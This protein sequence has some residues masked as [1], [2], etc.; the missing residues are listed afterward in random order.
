MEYEAIKVVETEGGVWELIL[1]NPPANALSK[2]MAYELRHAAAQLSTDPSVRSVVLHGEGKVFFGGGDLV[3]F[4]DGGGQTPANLHEMT[5]DF[6]GALSRMARMD[7]PVVGAITGTAGG[8]GMSLTAAMD[9]V[10]AGESAKFTMA[11]T[12]AG[13]TPDGTSTF[14]LARVVGLRRATE[15]VLTNRVLSAADA[16]NWG[17]IN[18]V[19]AD[20]QVLDEARALAAKLA[21]GP[22]HAFGGSKR[23]L[24]GG[25]NS[26]LG[27]AM[28]REAMSIAN[29]ALH[30][31]AV[32]GI[33][34]F[35]GKRRP[36]FNPG[37]GLNN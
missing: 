14:F 7:A 20:D 8:A 5:I 37:S 9:L 29:Q 34:A 27:E 26:S 23:L 32:E 1:S 28:E 4:R 16:L 19:H 24:I 30:P 18:A 3:E 22:L 31:E 33:D 2:Q 15:L 12:A 25:A 17:L 11:Y 6:H 13:L 35:L 36:N 10:Y 21:R